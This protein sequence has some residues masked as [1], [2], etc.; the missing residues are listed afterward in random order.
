MVV[1]PNIINASYIPGFLV[2]DDLTKRKRG[3]Y[4]NLKILGSKHYWCR[5]E[6]TSVHLFQQ[7]RMD[8]YQTCQM[9]LLRRAWG[10]QD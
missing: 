2:W 8:L 7:E 9:L 6:I 3:L 5:L 1:R 10:M 4:I